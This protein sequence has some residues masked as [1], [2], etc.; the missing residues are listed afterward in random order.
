MFI[1]RVYTCVLY[2]C[3]RSD[4]NNTVNCDGAKAWKLRNQ[5][6]ALIIKFELHLFCLCVCIQYT[7]GKS[8]PKHRVVECFSNSKKKSSDLTQINASAVMIMDEHFWRTTT[9]RRCYTP[10][11]VLAHPPCHKMSGIWLLPPSPRLTW[12][13]SLF[14]KLQFSV[15]TALQN[16]SAGS[17]LGRK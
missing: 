4:S 11:P 2:L 17:I 5:T 7:P 3:K 13:S 16:C 8:S 10:A 9:Q 6:K 15:P 14:R 1:C 12:A